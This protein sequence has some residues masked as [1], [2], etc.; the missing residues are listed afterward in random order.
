MD[1]LSVTVTRGA[2]AE[3]RHCVHAVAVR[4]GAIVEAAGD[5]DLVTFMRSAAKPIQALPAVGGLRDLRSEEIAIACASHAASDEQLAAVRSLLARAGAHEDDLECGEQDGSKLRHNC[6]GKHAAMLLYARARGWP[7]AGYR[8]ADH[9]LQQELVRLVGKAAGLAPSEIRTGT[10][11]CGVVSF[12]MRL[13]D[14]A[15]IFSRLV[16]RQLPSAGRVV[17]AMRIHPELVGGPKAVDTAVMR[18]L[19]GAIAKRGAEGVLCAGLPDGTGVAIKV[20]D[21]ANR[22]TGP[23]AGSF[24]HIPELVESPVFN[25]R[26]ERVGLISGRS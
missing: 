17:E 25:S 8:L 12:A 26:G 13:R 1:V 19:P 21:G 23:A 2:L 10:D 20:E 9:P 22:A 6:S 18:A 3:S 24:L 7:L 15:T 14:I 16:A 4:N 5:P 11:G